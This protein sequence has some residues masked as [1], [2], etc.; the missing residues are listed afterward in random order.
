VTVLRPAAPADV[1][2]LAELVR[3]AYGHYVERIGRPPG[4]MTE[5]YAEVVDRSQVVVAERDG[6]IAGLIVLAV[7]DEGFLVEN[8]AVD[9]AHQGRGVGRALLEH[10][11]ASARR[12][13]FDSI[14]LYTHETMTENQALYARIGY[15]EY[16]RR[17]QGQDWLVYLRKPLG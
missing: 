17:R 8:V 14:Y 11:E 7:G 13:G 2:R 10:A 12:E 3:A 4:P 5:D 15:A 1:P 6:E 16:D 9:P